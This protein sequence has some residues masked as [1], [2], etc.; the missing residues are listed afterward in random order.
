[1]ARW[2]S[3]IDKLDILK[4]VVGII[5]K[6]DRSLLQNEGKMVDS[7]V[8]GDQGKGNYTTLCSLWQDKSSCTDKFNIVKLA[9]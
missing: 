6:K 4:L 5:G 7:I 2:S 3:Y 9:V 8:E 1:M